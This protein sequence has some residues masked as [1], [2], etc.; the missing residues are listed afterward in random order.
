MRR[1]FNFDENESIPTF[2]AMLCM[3]CSS[4]LRYEELVAPCR[5]AAPF[6]T[7]PIRSAFLNQLGRN[8]SAPI[9]GRISESKLAIEGIVEISW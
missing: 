2:R 7:R 9:T 6:S 4:A 8:P 5:H 3:N 1:F